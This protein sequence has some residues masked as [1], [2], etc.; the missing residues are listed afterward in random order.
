M[1]RLLSSST[2]LD[3]TKSSYVDTTI[4]TID[5]NMIVL[6]NRVP[7]RPLRKKKKNET[8]GRWRREMILRS[9][10]SEFW[11]AGQER[12]KGRRVTSDKRTTTKLYHSL[13]LLLCGSYYNSIAM[14][15]ER[16]K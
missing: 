5:I 7:D 4:D 6:L 11:V 1:D 15:I 9:W 8:R 2:I 10:A 12:L 16:V 3:E 13:L 14:I